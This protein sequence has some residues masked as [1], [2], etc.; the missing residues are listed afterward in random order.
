[1]R[2]KLRGIGMAKFNDPINLITAIQKLL[3]AGAA[4]AATVLLAV[5]IGGCASSRLID[6]GF[7]FDA[8][9]D[10]PGVTVLNYS[11]S[12]RSAPGWTLLSIL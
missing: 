8:R 1:M 11:Y 3:R 4:L 12:V 2:T 7:V 10:S 6:H 5:V 9:L